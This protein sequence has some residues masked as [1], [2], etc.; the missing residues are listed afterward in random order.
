MSSAE[1]WPSVELPGVTKAIEHRVHLGTAGVWAWA[2]GCGLC[3][4]GLNPPQHCC[5]V[6]PNSH[7]LALV[8]AGCGFADDRSRYQMAGGEGQTVRSP[9]VPQE[10]PLTCQEM[11]AYSRYKEGGLV[12]KQLQFCHKKPLERHDAIPLQGSCSPVVRRC[13]HQLY[14]NILY[15][16]SAV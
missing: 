13:S 2:V 9:A 10:T 8:V 4:S 7:R 11:P 1:C 14:E 16:Y 6:G 3:D 5:A 15:G 12:R